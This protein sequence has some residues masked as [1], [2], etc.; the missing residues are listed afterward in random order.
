M[1]QQTKPGTVLQFGTRSFL[2]VVVV[3]SVGLA[4]VVPF[5]RSQPSAFARNLVWGAVISTAVTLTGLL[6]LCL[7][8]WWVE[9]RGGPILLRPKRLNPSLEY[10]P[11]IIMVVVFSCILVAAG[12]SLMPNMKEMSQ[13]NQEFGWNVFSVFASVSVFAPVMLALMYSITL[14]WWQVSPM[15]LEI[16]EK[17]VCI[18]GLRFCQWNAITGCQ[19]SEGKQVA[20]LTLRS[21][22]RKIVALLP[23]DAREAVQELFEGRDIKLQ[24]DSA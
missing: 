18:G 4:V 21:G 6:I 22:S 7:R 23:V 20:I 24:R 2:I 9:S 14:F 15:T 16:R 12:V 5:I 19:W 8:R 11:I 13:L 10:L 17:G 3:L 1:S